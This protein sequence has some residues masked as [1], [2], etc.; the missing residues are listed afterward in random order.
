MENMQDI[1]IGANACSPVQLKTCLA[2]GF[3][4]TRRL[5]KNLASLGHAMQLSAPWSFK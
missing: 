5:A 2:G 4:L 1:S 3:S